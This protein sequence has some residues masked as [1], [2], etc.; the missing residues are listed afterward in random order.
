M[1]LLIACTKGV[2][3]TGTQTD[4]SPP[5]GTVSLAPEVLTAAVDVVAATTVEDDDDDPV[6]WEFAWS[7]DGVVV[8]EGF[9]NWI[10]AGTAVMGQE[11]SVDATPWDGIDYGETVTASGSLENALPAVTSVLI[12][13]EEPLEGEALDCTAEGEDADGDTLSWTITWLVNGE[14]GGSEVLADTTLVGETW[15]CVAVANDGN[16]DSWPGEAFVVI[17]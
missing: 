13:P 12:S 5:V 1:L 9:Q 10:P 4:N 17:Q 14:D 8:Q 2:P 6:V 11:V 3:D 7:V 15:T 16:T